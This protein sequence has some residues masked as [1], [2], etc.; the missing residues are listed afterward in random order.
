MIKPWG[1]SIIIGSA[2]F[3]FFGN[4]EVWHYYCN[5]WNKVIFGSKTILYKLL[6]V[7]KF[8]KFSSMSVGQFFVIMLVWTMLCSS[9]TTW[10][11]LIWIPVFIVHLKASL[12]LI[13]FIITRINNKLFKNNGQIWLIREVTSSLWIK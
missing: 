11:L 8:S 3:F 13:L 4:S 10:W 6:F 2:V 1:K 5:V 9:Q 7:K 12:K